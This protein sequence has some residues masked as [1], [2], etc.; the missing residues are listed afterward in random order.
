MVDQNVKTHFDWFNCHNIIKQFVNSSNH[1]GLTYPYGQLCLTYSIQHYYTTYGP[2]RVPDKRSISVSTNVIVTNYTSRSIN[3]IIIFLQ[4]ILATRTN[5]PVWSWISK[6]Q[7]E[8]K[9]SGRAP[10]AVAAKDQALTHIITYIYIYNNII[11]Y[12]YNTSIRVSHH[13]VCTR[14]INNRAHR[15][16]CGLCI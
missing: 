3:I 1:Y 6:N 9:D 15:D 5:N 7:K 14:Q 13:A 16:Y 4:H 10:A 12:Y 8:S 2:S 11:L